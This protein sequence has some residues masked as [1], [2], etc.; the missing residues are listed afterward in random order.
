MIPDRY[1][2]RIADE[3]AVLFGAPSA[4]IVDNT[5]RGQRAAQAVFER[6]GGSVLLGLHS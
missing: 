2:R 3:D 1:M 5:R 4:A 6:G